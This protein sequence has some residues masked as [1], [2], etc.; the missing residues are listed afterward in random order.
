MVCIS[1]KRVPRAPLQSIT[2]WEKPDTP[3]HTVHVD[4]LGPLPVSNGY[5]FVVLII[6]A[7]TKFSLLY[8]ITK[9]DS[10]ELK[11]VTTQAVSMFGVPKLMIT[12]KGRM[13]ES[14]DFISFISELGC[15]LH[16]I[17]P[18]MHHVNGQAERYMRTVLNM[19]RIQKNYKNASWSESLGKLQL[20]L[21]ITKQKTTQ[22]SPLNL[23]IGTEATTPVIRALVRDVA[24][25][26]PVPNREALRE[27]TRSRARQHLRDNQAKQDETTNRQR[28]PPRQFDINHLV[29]VIKFSQVTG[30]LDP[31]MRGLYK[32]VKVLPSGRYALRLLSGSYGKTT[33]AAAQHMVPWRGEWCPDM[34]AAFF[35]SKLSFT[36][37]LL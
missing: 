36:L 15:D 7:F 34:C 13:F 8:P 10:A 2:S 31:G 9:Q 3:F 28:Q 21:N 35:E 6:D 19:L 1:Q 16:Y 24:I 25:E 18:E 20:V 17:T 4:V 26:D 14:N 27:L 33:Q 11:R 22:V 5:K 32:V 12:D 23:L 30:K 37:L 29:F